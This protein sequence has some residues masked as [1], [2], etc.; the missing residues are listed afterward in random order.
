LDYVIGIDPGATGA[1]AL[2][3]VTRAAVL[4]V[5]DMP[6]NTVVLTSGKK[7]NRVDF[8]QLREILEQWKLAALKV[9]ASI[10][11]HIEHVQA[12]GKQSAP[13][14]FN[15]GYAAA[16]PFAICRMLD[17]EVRLVHPA[18]W[19]N[20]FGLKASAKDEARLLALKLFPYLDNHLRRK[21]DVDRADAILMAAY[22]PRFK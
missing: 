2:Y 18:T 21:M 10:Y 8:D 4:A 17:L 14:A 7:S 16:I 22:K 12:F 6:S 9:D 15:F 20:Q 11:V 3:N 19:K 13:A 1:L 5:K